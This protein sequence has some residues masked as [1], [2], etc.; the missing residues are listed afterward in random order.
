MPRTST[1]LPALAVLLG[2]LLLTPAR[3]R[4]DDAPTQQAPVATAPATAPANTPTD[5]PAAPTAP[6]SADAPASP[7]AADAGPPKAGELTEAKGQIRAK[8]GADPER[9]L[10]QGN[11]VYAE[12]DLATGPEDKGR[13]TFADGSTLDIGPDSRVLLADFV[14]DPANLDASKQAIRMAKGMFRYVSGKVVQNDPARLRLES[15]LA[16]I[17]IR[18]T[19]LDHKIVTEVKTVKGVKT[20]TVKDELHALR[21]TKQSQVVVDQHGLKTVLTKPDQAVFLRPKLP[22]SVRALTDQEKAEFAT[23]PPTPAPFDPRPGRGGFVG[24]GS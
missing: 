17:G 13:V 3:A 20:E 10:A 8:R 6:V 14:Y 22:G 24:G 21:A 9:A 2:C 19:T 4:A 15:P 16:V 5:T 1:L 18:G 11:P 23:I 7:P 12:D